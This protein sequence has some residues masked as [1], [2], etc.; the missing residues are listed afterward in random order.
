MTRK[1]N[2]DDMKTAMKHLYFVDAFD[3][4]RCAWVRMP[5]LTPDLAFVYFREMC[6]NTK[7]YSS[8]SV[9]SENR[10]DEEYNFYDEANKCVAHATLREAIFGAR[11]QNYHEQN[12]KDRKTFDSYSKDFK[13]NL[14]RFS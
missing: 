7:K 13:E 2:I 3:N 1:I 11:Y 9:T 10:L 5:L 6:L 14:I 8:V 4:E 12:T